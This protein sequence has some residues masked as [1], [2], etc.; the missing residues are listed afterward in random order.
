VFFDAS[1]KPVA[2]A[3]K[4]LEAEAEKEAEFEQNEG[5]MPDFDWDH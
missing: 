5:Q 4:D 2:S 1:D 3:A